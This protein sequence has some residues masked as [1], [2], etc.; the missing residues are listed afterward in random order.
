MSTNTVGVVNHCVIYGRAKSGKT[1]LIPTAPNPVVCNSDKGLSSIREFDIPFFPVNTYNDY[2]AFEAAAHSG[3]FDGA[4][5]FIDDLTEVA[6][7][8]LTE[9]LPKHKNGLQAYG[10]LNIEMSR[11]VRFWRNCTRLTA[12]L[13]CKQDRIKDYSTGGV[14]YAPMIP[15][16]AIP[17]M[18]PYLMGSVFHME[19]YTNP[20]DQTQTEVLRCKQNAQY[21]AGDRSG[22]LNELE[23]AN[24]TNVFAKVMS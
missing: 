17:Q 18:L 12:V 15:G 9:E 20:A 11:V 10:A 5:V 24:L 6:E 23:F 21:E 2:L 3:Q 7:M 19:S 16:Q 13:I 8:L 22:K 1:R 14:I 4:T